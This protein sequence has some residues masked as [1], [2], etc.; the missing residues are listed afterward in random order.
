MKVQ[1]T[2]ESKLSITLRFS[3]T[4][5]VTC[6]VDMALQDE[7]WYHTS[8]AISPTSDMEVHINGIQ[9]KYY[10]VENVSFSSVKR[11]IPLLTPSLTYLLTYSLTHLLTHSLTYSH[12]LTHSLTYLLTYSLTYSLTPSLTHSL[13]RF[14]CVCTHILLI[15][16]DMCCRKESPMSPSTRSIYFQIYLLLRKSLLS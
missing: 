11:W 14:A 7:R 6:D 3:E 9:I 2:V 5:K 12:S 13:T 1:L 10:C 4:R 8:V 16:Y 15:G